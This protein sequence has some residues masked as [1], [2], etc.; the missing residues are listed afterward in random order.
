MQLLSLCGAQC[1][2]SLRSAL[3]CGSFLFP[4]SCSPTHP[5]PC[6][7]SPLLRRPRSYFSPPLPPDFL[8]S[9]DVLYT[10]PP[11]LGGS[12]STS[13]PYQGTT[14]F[15]QWETSWKQLLS[16]PFHVCKVYTR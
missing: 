4:P 9:P 5:S 7:F 11:H 8:L 1:G 16:M 14:P 3:L 12:W 10:H 6:N 2:S 13:I 15:F